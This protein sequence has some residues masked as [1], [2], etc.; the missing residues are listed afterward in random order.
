M[1]SGA[2]E[3]VQW[4]RAIAAL[5][6]APSLVP[7]SYMVDNCCVRID[8]PSGTG[9]AKSTYSFIGSVPSIAL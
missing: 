7:R 6:E 2:V 3:M 5:K 9:Q 1:L 8:N 4:K